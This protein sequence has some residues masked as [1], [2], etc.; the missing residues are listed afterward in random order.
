MNFGADTKLND[1][2]MMQ[3]KLDSLQMKLLEASDEDKSAIEEEIAELEQKLV[4]FH[5]FQQKILI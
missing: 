2:E 1:Q 5:N 4:W 3:E